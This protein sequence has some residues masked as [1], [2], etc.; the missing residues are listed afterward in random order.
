MVHWF[1]KHYDVSITGTQNIETIIVP[2][3]TKITLRRHLLSYNFNSI[4]GNLC[5]TGFNKKKMKKFIYN[6]IHIINN[7]Y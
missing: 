3:E 5:I 2:E 6:N 1:C 7:K 4:Y